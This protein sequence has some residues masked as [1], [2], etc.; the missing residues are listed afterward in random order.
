[1]ASN[2]RQIIRFLL[3][4]THAR[5][6][7]CAKQWFGSK[8]G[9]WC[10]VTIATIS[11]LFE[12]EETIDWFFWQSSVDATGLDTRAVEASTWNCH[13]GNYL[14]MTANNA[15]VSFI[16]LIWQN[17]PAPIDM[18]YVSLWSE[19]KWMAQMGTGAHIRLQRRFISFPLQAI[20]LQ[21]QIN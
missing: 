12:D 8:E 2:K 9:Q 18:H 5:T 13:E 21:L 15:L 4:L 7:L 1:M 19:A 3:I 6:F 10:N 20:S 17:T 11:W 16:S 14:T